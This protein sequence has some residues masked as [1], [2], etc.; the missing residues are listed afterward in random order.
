MRKVQEM[1]NVEIRLAIATE[2][3]RFGW[4]DIRIEF[5]K[6]VGESRRGLSE[7]AVEIPNWPG[8]LDVAMVLWEIMEVHGLRELFA[9][10][11]R[12]IAGIGIP[13]ARHLAEAAVTTI[14]NDAACSCA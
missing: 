4:K 2:S 14:R 5:G 8:D 9:K 7:M 13:S 11:V 1:T 3:P 10:N 6:L 12:D